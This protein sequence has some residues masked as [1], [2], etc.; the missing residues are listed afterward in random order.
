MRTDAYNPL[1]GALRFGF[2]LLAGVAAATVLLFFA[3]F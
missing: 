1:L 2:L 3:M